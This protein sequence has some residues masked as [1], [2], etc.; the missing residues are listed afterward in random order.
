MATEY[1]S[2]GMTI[3]EVQ[4]RI[5]DILGWDV[6]NADQLA[7][8]NMA[9]TQAGL[10]AT[11]YQGNIWWWMR[12]KCYFTTYDD[13]TISSI[14]RSSNTVTVTTASAHGYTVNS[15]VKIKGTSS[16]TFE[17]IYTIAS[18]PSSTTF[19]YAQAG[20]DETATGGTTSVIGYP[21]QT[22]ANQMMQNLRAVER[23]TYADQWELRFVERP[24]FFQW[25]TLSTTS[26]TGKPTHYTYFY[27][28]RPYI[29][30]YPACGGQYQI[31]IQY[32][33]RHS[34]IDNNSS[35]DAL[36]VPPEYQYDV[37]V[38]GGAWLLKNDLLGD[39]DL[40]QC[41]AF[42]NAMRRMTASEPPSYITET[43]QIVY[44]ADK[45]VI[46]NT[47]FLTPDE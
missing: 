7:K 21:L 46:E 26:Y 9:I 41:P 25:H 1:T 27:D 8:I 45:P 23:V 42:V 11:T 20:D 18:V 2:P 22:V 4:A 31:F 36:I 28:N 43:E 39:T 30:L 24:T 44:P 16:D 10:A 13:N 19:T 40:Q 5:A 33:C 37:Y 35:D 6:N 12:K 29:G 32:I 3:A 38:R 34:K 15:I 17:G 14:S 47:V